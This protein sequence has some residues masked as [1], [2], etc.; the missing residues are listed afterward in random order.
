VHRPFFTALCE[1]ANDDARYSN[2]SHVHR[3]YIRGLRSGY[4]QRDRQPTYQTDLGLNK[5]RAETLRRNVKV[6]SCVNSLC[7]S[8]GKQARPSSSWP[9]CPLR[10]SRPVRLILQTGPCVP[11][12]GKCQ[13]HVDEPWQAQAVQLRC[14]LAFF[15]AMCAHRPILFA[16]DGRG[17]TPDLRLLPLTLRN[18]AIWSA[19]D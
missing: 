17:I 8:L 9:P 1:T 4:D 15:A 13:T 10:P 14:D 5:S 11:L 3:Q 16:Q 18:T 6:L 2:L 12:R 7:Q 19:S